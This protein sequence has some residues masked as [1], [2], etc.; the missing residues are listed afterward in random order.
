MSDDLDFEIEV[1]EADELDE[2]DASGGDSSEENFRSEKAEEVTQDFE[3]EDFGTSKPRK[4]SCSERV[5]SDEV[6]LT[7]N[8]NVE[9]WSRISLGAF[10]SFQNGNAFSKSDWGEDGYPIIRIQNLTGEADGYNYYDGDLEHRYRVDSGDTLLTW[11]ATIGVFEWEGPTAAL[12]QHIF[13]VETRGEVNDSFFH[14]K[15][16]ELIPQ[17]EALSHGSTMKHVRKADL[18][19]IDVELPPLPEQ[20][21]IAS[22]LYTVDQAIQKTEAII[23]Q[24]KRL[25]EG[26]RRELLRNGFYDH[27]GQ[28]NT[29]TGVYPD[30]WNIA[31][32]D[33]LFELNSGDFLDSSKRKE[34]G[35]YP[36]YGGN[37]I[38][39]YTDQSTVPVGALVIG[40][41]GAYCGNVH[42]T[43]SDA[44]V[45]DN[46][47][48]V[49]NLS[50]RVSSRFLKHVLTSVGLNRFA[51]QS[52]QP[53]ISQSTLK[54]LK[55]PIPSQEEQSKIVE[56]LNSITD[57]VK[58]G[59]Q[60]VTE[61]RSI[62]KGLMQDLLTGEI[63]TADKAIEVLDEVE[64][65]G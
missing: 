25:H 3:K 65:H 7:I 50:D 43:I 29:A 14:F 58:N 30:D 38:M 21:K 44:W 61:L 11:S 5:T 39:G 37:G 18:V 34:D 19:N 1:V 46:A 28:Q 63:R 17:L 54:N 16:E 36:V 22:V 35:A 15:L 64:A 2:L 41:V 42:I 20:R 27:A 57:T 26:T 49:K 32:G 23:E 24:A 33:R 51:E 47:I 13:N 62:K 9:G 6:A 60:S 48:I 55:L 59:E 8:P 31:R 56:T 45:T 52:A 4:E 53:R 10:A 40:R 12:N